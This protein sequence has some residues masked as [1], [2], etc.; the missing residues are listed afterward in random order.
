[1][2]DGLF[3]RLDRV[4]INLVKAFLGAPPP[5]KMSGDYWNALQR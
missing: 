4:V 3:I 2:E 5:R 1:M